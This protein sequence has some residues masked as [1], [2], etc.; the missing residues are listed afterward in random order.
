MA[1]SSRVERIQNVLNSLSSGN[2]D[3]LG[4]ALISEDGLIIASRLPAGMD[5]ERV[6]AVVAALQS[7]AERAAQQIELGKISKMMVFA[8]KGGALLYVGKKAS[9][10][11]FTRPTAKLG[12]VLME[13][14]EAAENLSDV[15]G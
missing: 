9:L 3:I 12:L 13:A 5:D 7:I 15:L 10:V 4:A 11:V 8:E 1:V 14:T 2:P 6:S